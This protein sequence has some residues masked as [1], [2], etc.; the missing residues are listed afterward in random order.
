MNT[1]LITIESQSTTQTPKH[2]KMFTERG[3]K[4]KKTGQKNISV[5][6]SNNQFH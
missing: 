1:Q 2:C 6:Y 3:K 4:K 5:A